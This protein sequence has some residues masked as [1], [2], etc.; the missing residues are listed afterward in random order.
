ME[1][2]RAGL[3]KGIQGSG[4]CLGA[5]WVDGISRKIEDWDEGQMWEA[6]E[7]KQ[8]DLHYWVMVVSLQPGETQGRA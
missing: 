4:R 1:L 5:H 3:E 2:T 6:G 7:R 8:S